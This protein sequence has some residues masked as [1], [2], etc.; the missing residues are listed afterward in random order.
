MSGQHELHSTLSSIFAAGLRCSEGCEAGTSN[1]PRQKTIKFFHYYNKLSRGS[2]FFVVGWDFTMWQI[3]REG[4]QWSGVDMSWYPGE[5]LIMLIM[6]TVV[7]RC[8]SNNDVSPGLGQLHSHWTRVTWLSMRQM[9][10]EQRD[11]LLQLII[12][13][14]RRSTLHL[15]PLLSHCM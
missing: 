14:A 13:A 6:L 3:I 10:A 1:I 15:S 8:W 9:G 2:L 5:G 4:S 12:R 7:S 11:Q